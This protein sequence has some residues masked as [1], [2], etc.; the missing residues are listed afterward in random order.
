MNYFYNEKKL[1][2]Y[3][4]SIYGYTIYDLAR[5]FNFVIPKNI[6]NKGYI[7]Q[8]IEKIFGVY[9]ANQA[10]S[11]FYNLGIELKTIPIN[12][13]RKSLEST[14]ICAT[15][16]IGINGVIWETSYLY[17][18]LKRILW[19]PI[20]INNAKSLKEYIIDLPFLWSPNFKEEK[21]IKQDWEDIMYFI[22]FGKIE[23]LNSKYG[24][25]LQV[26]KKSNNKSS[27]TQ[28]IGEYG[29]KIFISPRSFYLRKNFT[30]KLINKNINEE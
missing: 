2:S 5:K 24:E 23:K 20:K 4:M 3:A 21:I 18:K 22:T 12:K 7:G 17:Y 1:I 14:F 11:D 19:I 6:E 25:I 10:V 8:I 29:Q 9:V 30:N 28:G 27:L 13:E 26:K 16:F 15:S